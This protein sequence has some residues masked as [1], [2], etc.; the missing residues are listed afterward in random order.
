MRLTRAHTKT[1]SMSRK[2]PWLPITRRRVVQQSLL[3]DQHQSTKTDYGVED[4]AK[5][6]ARR[7]LAVQQFFGISRRSCTSSFA[8]MFI[9]SSWVATL[10]VCFTAVVLS[11]VIWLSEDSTL[12]GF[13]WP[14]HKTVSTR[15]AANIILLMLAVVFYI[16]LSPTVRGMAGRPIQPPRSKTVIFYVWLSLNLFWFIAG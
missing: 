2:A 12:A 13:K 15:A 14:W 16:V 5:H 1:V 9:H 8:Q 10:T 4:D 3:K 11:I 7:S 6:F